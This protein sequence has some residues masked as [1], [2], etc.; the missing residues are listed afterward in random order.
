MRTL[1]ERVVIARK[2]KGMTQGQVAMAAGMTQTML[3]RIERG[4]A[5]STK[6]IVSLAGA[7][8]VRPEWLDREEGE[9]YAPM[10]R[11]RGIKEALDE[12][13]S[14]VARSDPLIRDDV[15]RFI[16]LYIKNPS[17]KIADVLK[18]MVNV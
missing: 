8:G 9:M 14:A 15:Y 6:D 17:P 12:V 18:T 5:Q 16:N 3:S 11:S 10:E 4:E 2:A 1:G 13:A 7:L